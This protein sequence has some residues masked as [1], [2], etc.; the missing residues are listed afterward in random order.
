MPKKPKAESKATQPPRAIKYSPEV[1]ERRAKYQRLAGALIT[2]LHAEHSECPEVLDVQPPGWLSP[3]PEPH[4][5]S[6]SIEEH[7]RALFENILVCYDDDFLRTLY[8]ELRL[9]YDERMLKCGAGVF[10]N[11]KRRGKKGGTQ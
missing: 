10:R 1:E 11:L 6:C 3:E 9:Y 2:M 7:F 5:L 4:I 8:V